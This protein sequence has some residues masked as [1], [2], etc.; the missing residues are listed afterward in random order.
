MSRYPCRLRS[1]DLVVPGQYR[2]EQDGYK[3]GPNPDLFSL[4]GEVLSWRTAN[5]RARATADETLTDI[6]RWNCQRFGCNEQWCVPVDS[7]VIQ[8]EAASR[9]RPC[10]GCGAVA[11]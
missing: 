6:E 4:R 3:W 11:H 8:S 1:Y 2:F 10:S 7:S 9:R 5:K